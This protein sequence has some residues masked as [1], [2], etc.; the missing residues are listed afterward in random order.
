MPLPLET[1]RLVLRPFADTDVDAFHANVLSDDEVM[2]WASPQR[3]AFTREESRVA[4]ERYVAQQ[5]R[6]GFSLWAVLERETGALVGNCGLIPF[7]W[8][9]PEIEVGYRIGRAWWG[10][11]YATEAALA[12]LE[13]GFADLEVDRIVAVTDPDNVR[14]QRV[15][16]KIGMRPE[17]RTLYRGEETLFYVAERG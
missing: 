12:S 14:S 6:A 4:L 1:E 5:E 9:G 2:R 10:R 11:G 17:G 3:R 16:E 13:L 8:E 7:G 15:L